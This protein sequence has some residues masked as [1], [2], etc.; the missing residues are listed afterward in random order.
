MPSTTSKAIVTLAA[1]YTIRVPT[2][3]MAMKWPVSAPRTG[4]TMMAPQTPETI[5][6]GDHPNQ[7]DGG[8]AGRGRSRPCHEPKQGSDQVATD[9]PAHYQI[10]ARK[11]P[12]VAW[13][14]RD[15]VGDRRA[16]VPGGFG[17]GD[18]ILHGACCRC[19]ATTGDEQRVGRRGGVD[20][21]HSA[22]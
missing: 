3:A 1:Q 9:Q 8:P 2:A 12:G 5:G 20:G 4:P 17:S 7:T 21:Q 18:D 6:V 10:E 15:S 11:S 22:C 19:A 14:G 16:A 13:L